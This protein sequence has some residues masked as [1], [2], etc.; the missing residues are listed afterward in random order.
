M[1]RPYDR[2]RFVLFDGVT[3]MSL[4]MCWLVLRKTILSVAGMAGLPIDFSFMPMAETRELFTKLTFQSRRSH[5]LVP[6]ENKIS[7]AEAFCQAKLD[8]AVLRSRRIV[9]CD[10]SSSWLAVAWVRDTRRV[11]ASHR[12]N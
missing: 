4:P 12:K 6:R 1:M 5:A 7:P 8:R 10:R 11:L 9:V 3:E 2:C